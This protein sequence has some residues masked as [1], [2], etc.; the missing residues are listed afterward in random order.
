MKKIEEAAACAAALYHNGMN[1]SIAVE[2]ALD[3]FCVEFPER[4]EIRSKICS[5]LGKRGVNKKASISTPK[6]KQ[7]PVKKLPEHF[8]VRQLEIKFPK[9]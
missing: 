3:E 8:L 1:F 7:R 9:R 2:R 6:K 5:L 4:K